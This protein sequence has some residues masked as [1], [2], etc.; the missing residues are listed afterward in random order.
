MRIAQIILPGISAY[1]RKSQRADHAAL[2]ER[3]EVAVMTLAE[4]RNGGVDVAHVYAGGELP[5]RDFRGFSVPYV[6]P[7]DVQRSRWMWGNPTAPRLIVT[8]ENLPEVVEDRY[9]GEPLTL[10]SPRAR[11]EG[12]VVGS[13]ARDA[14][15]NSVDQTRMRIERFRND[16]AWKIFASEP[17]PADLAG[18]D[19]WIDPAVDDGDLDGFVAEALVVGLPVVA[20]RT[21]VNAQRLE[22]GRTGTLVPPR[23]PNEM[24]H[25]ILATLFKS[26]VRESKIRAAR[27]TAS[28][29]RARHRLRVLT[30]IY[31]TLI[32]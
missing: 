3:H 18:V 22:Q 1:E 10:P 20:T 9:F 27:Q 17:A 12:K 14:T 24:T 4:A 19:L 25:A 16:V 30:S 29:F 8:A 32:A 26:E 31:E 6:A 15:A 11:G 28:K 13:F 5:A 7:F 23:D 21:R 2:S